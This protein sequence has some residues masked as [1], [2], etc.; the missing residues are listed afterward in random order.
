MVCSLLPGLHRRTKASSV[1]WTNFSGTAIA[2]KDQL[3][4]WGFLSSH[5]AVTLGMKD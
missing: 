5:L 1:W 2:D 3:E 4:G